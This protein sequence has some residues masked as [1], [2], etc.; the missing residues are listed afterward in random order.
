MISHLLPSLLKKRLFQICF[1]SFNTL[2]KLVGKRRYAKLHC[3]EDSNYVFP[4]IK[5]R[6]LGSQFPYS[7]HTFVSGFFIPRIGPP[8]LLQLNR[9]TAR[10]IYKSL[11]DVCRNL[12]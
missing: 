12:D 7:I 8:I 2:R 3:K 4:E 5:L 11:K 10:G 1:Q 9:Q 6:G